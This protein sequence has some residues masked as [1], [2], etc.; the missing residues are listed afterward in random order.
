IRMEVNADRYA[1]SVTGRPAL[2]GAL[3]RMLAAGPRRLPFGT[4]AIVAGFNTVV[5]AFLFLFLAACARPAASSPMMG[6]DTDMDGMMQR[7]MAPL[8]EEYAG[9]ANPVRADAGSIER[10]RAIYASSCAA[11]HG[12][13]GRGDGPAVE[14]LSPAPA[15]LARSAKML[16]DAYLFYRVSEGG[17]FA[18]FDSAMPPF[19]T[20]L[21]EA[22]RWDL[23]NY[24]R[25]FS[26][27]PGG[28]GPMMGDGMMPGDGMMDGNWM[29]WMM[30][31][32]SI[33]GWVL[34][35]VGVVAIV[36]AVVWVVR[37]GRNTRE[38]EDTPLEILK[39]RYAKGELTGDQFEQM[40]RRLVE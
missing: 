30:V 15:P 24:L 13:E 1:V 28:D 3:Q 19:K 23:I 33:L 20:A 4:A 32:W 22:E 5:F 39:R 14:N 7:H 34:S 40:K 21:S 8:P 26:A 9:L 36:L 35:L 16:S 12:D 31:P 18:P 6:P 25:G 10:G 29:N 37:R 2:A 38:P 27:R 17:G 11:C